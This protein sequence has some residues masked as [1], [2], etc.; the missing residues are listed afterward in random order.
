M[1]SLTVLYDSHCGLCRKVKEWLEAQPAYIPLEFVAAGSDEAAARYPSLDPFDTQANLTVVSDDG[2]VYQ[3][4]AGFVMCLYALVD[5][6][7]WSLSFATPLWRPVLRLCLWLLERLRRTSVCE[8][9]C[10]VHPRFDV[11]TARPVHAYTPRR[12]A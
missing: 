9:A 3:G 4:E 2:Q 1:R 12:S 11:L 10:Q 5:Y 6:R 8:G 7:G